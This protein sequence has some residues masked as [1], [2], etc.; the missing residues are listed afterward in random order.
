MLRIACF[1]G[2]E[3][4][5]EEAYK[6]SL[7][8]EFRKTKKCGYGE[9]CTFAH[10]EEELR[11]PPKAHPKY[12]TQLC[13]NFIRD[14]YCPYG[15]RCMYIHERCNGSVGFTDVMKIDGPENA[16]NNSSHVDSFSVGQVNGSIRCM[17][18]PVTRDKCPLYAGKG[19]FCHSLTSTGFNRAGNIGYF[20]ETVSNQ[21]AENNAYGNQPLGYINPVGSNSIFDQLNPVDYDRL[22]L[23]L[24][25]MLV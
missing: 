24:S 23:Q 5:K 17:S 7:C 15:D 18:S 20:A 25:N 1:W 9:R 12:K 10:G 13:K 6:T 8:G 14:N 16:E 2:G 19:D 21:N 22:L 11:P 3:R 4:R